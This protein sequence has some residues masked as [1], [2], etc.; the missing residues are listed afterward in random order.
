MGPEVIRHGI[1][2]GVCGAV[3]VERRRQAPASRDIQLSAGAISPPIL[4]S[5]GFYDKYICDLSGIEPG[6]LER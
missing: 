6:S 1:A 5:I 2:R 4:A 3:G